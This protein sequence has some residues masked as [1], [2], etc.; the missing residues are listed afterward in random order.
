M[1]AHLS[2]PEYVHVLLNPL[3]VYGL[4][5]GMLGLVIAILLKT[6]TARVTA[7]ALVMLSAASAWPVYYYG[8][9]GY[10]RVK[11]MVDEDG[12]K[13]LE[14]HMRRG[15]K[16]IYVFYLVAALS[17]SA[18][19]VEFAWPKAAVPIAI[20]T[21]VVAMATLVVGAYIAQ[22][23]GRVRHKEFRFEEPP[24]PKMTTPDASD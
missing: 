12:D 3:P 4:A 14:E 16:L 13:W 17:A 9:A 23:G 20:A 19:V 7:I 22:A 1:I 24:E 21:L 2:K 5:V 11:A 10:D 18:I 15:E 6:R 8:G